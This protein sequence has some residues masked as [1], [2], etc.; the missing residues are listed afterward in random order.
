MT[1]EREK[2]KEDLFE[3]LDR[4][5]APIQD[6]DWPEPAEPARTGVGEAEGEPERPREEAEE[7]GAAAPPGEPARFAAEEPVPAEEPARFA[8]EEE[9]PAE[10]PVPSE[11]P[12]EE[13]LPAEEPTRAWGPG[14]PEEPAEVR[15]E[16]TPAEELAAT[17]EVAAAGGPEAP[18]PAGTAQPPEE[19]PT[20]EDLEAAAEHF[21]ESL[22]MEE[23]REPGEA[24]GSPQEVEQRLLADLE[25]PAAEPRTVKVGPEGLGGPSWQEPTTLEVGFEAEAR[26]PGRDVPAAFVTGLV[27]AGIAI[28]S[29]AWSKTAFAVVA[30]ILVLVAQGELYGVLRRRHH[31]PATAVGL[32]TGALVLAAGYARGEAAMLAMLGLGTMATYLWYMAA[33]PSQRHHVTREVALTLLPVVYVALLAGYALTTLAIPAPPD[34][35]ALL[36]AVL[37]LTFVYD[38]AAFVVGAWWGSRPLAPSI[39]PKKSWE[40]AI[41]GTVVV[42]LVS[43]GVVASAVDALESVARS[44]GLA[45]VV[46]VFATLGDLAESLI[47][48]DLGVKD[49]GSILPGHGGVLDRIDSVLFV[50]PAAL[51]FFRLVLV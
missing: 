38:T 16:A 35:R 28:G 48:R 17:R 9:A 46:A 4:F 40:G 29:L 21:A 50:A 19:P 31:H 37:G 34:G 45:L 13:P 42:L 39:S 14:T 36:L 44:V 6:V 51:V 32:S 33:P 12:A 2:E 47:K 43:V 11:V 30:G 25:R 27:L 8:A 3:D 1:E 20:E 5:F 49:M 23:A 15:A 41:G 26:A 22:R 7:E 24:P 18:E 10:E